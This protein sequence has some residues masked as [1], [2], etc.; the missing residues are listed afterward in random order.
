VSAAPFTAPVTASVV[1]HVAAPV[2]PF[3]PTGLPMP[4]LPETL[5]IGIPLYAGVD[6]LDV[7]APYEVFGTMAGEVK[8]RCAVS[9]QLLGETL[10]PVATRFGAQLVP[11]A[12]FDAVGALDVLWVPGGSIEALETLMAGGTYLDALKRWS[13]GARIVASVC[14]G[15]MLLAAAGLLD[16]FRATT[17]W[18]F[19]PCF[20]RFPAVKPV[21]GKHHHWPRFVMDPRK[22]A[23][24]ATGIR[25]TGAG[26]SAGLD[27]ALQLVV[28][29]AGKKV[30]KQ[31][32]IAIQYFPD[33]P[34]HATLKPA[35]SC[36]L[37]PG[38]AQ[39]S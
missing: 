10:A 25:V 39:V 38:E 21:G 29:L 17:H 19:L 37:S 26:I 4:K 20:S 24:D 6:P 30:A 16:G 12:T 23:K 35:K 28:L 11:Q 27:E 32:Q 34:V 8:D 7:A 22:P 31:V 15:A 3:L 5:S 33:P 18:A 2:H 1:A 36:P 14:E 13:E 9:V